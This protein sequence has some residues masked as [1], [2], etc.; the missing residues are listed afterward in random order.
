MEAAFPEC[1]VRAS[2][3]SRPLDYPRR[4][5]LISLGEHTRRVWGLGQVEGG[6]LAEPWEVVLG[7]EDH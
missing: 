5:T 2:M 6:C 4:G 7:N 1:L 3:K